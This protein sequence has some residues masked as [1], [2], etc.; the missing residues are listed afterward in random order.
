MYN[1]AMQQIQKDTEQPEYTD[2]S[3]HLVMNRMQPGAGMQHYYVD[4]YIK[5]CGQPENEVQDWRPYFFRVKYNIAARQFVDEYLVDAAQGTPVF[6]F[7]RFPDEE[8]VYETRVYFKADGGFCYATQTVKDKDGGQT[9]KELDEEHE[10]V[11]SLTVGSSAI[12][13]WSSYTMNGVY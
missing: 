12:Y 11:R 6:I 8:E 5:D 9:V 7:S 13:E 1:A 3:L 4:M 2:N 10:D